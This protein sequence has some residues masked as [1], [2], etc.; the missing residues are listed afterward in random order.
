VSN[1]ARIL[2]VDDDVDLLGSLC[3]GLFLYGY[4]P[5]SA[6]GGL[7][8]IQLLEQPG[9]DGFDL[10]LTDLTMPAGSGLELIRH[11]RSV[12]PSLPI[13]AFTGVALGVEKDEVRALGIQIL[14]KPFTPDQ[15]DA[16]LRATL[17][18]T[19]EVSA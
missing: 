14:L 15:L 2:V 10:L 18:H 8:A 1:R 9:A 17:A 4:D 5:A 6:R 7:E 12:R 3:H 11:V 19:L 16:L 13:V